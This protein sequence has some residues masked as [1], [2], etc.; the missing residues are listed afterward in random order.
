MNTLYAKTNMEYKWCV[1]WEGIVRERDCEL[2][3]ER[4]GQFLRKVA[5]G[6]KCYNLQF[7]KSFFHKTLKIWTISAM[8][9]SAHGSVTLNRL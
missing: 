6:G 4:K 9:D 5:S 8:M 1:R 3:S 2:G 7:N